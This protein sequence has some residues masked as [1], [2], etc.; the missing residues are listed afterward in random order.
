MRAILA[1]ERDLKEIGRAHR[2]PDSQV[3]SIQDFRSSLLP[4]CPGNAFGH[5]ESAILN[6]YNLY[7]KARPH[8]TPK[9]APRTDDGIRQCFCS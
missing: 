8:G 4:L 9:V 3:L 7:S 6:L 2:L 5:I 1:G